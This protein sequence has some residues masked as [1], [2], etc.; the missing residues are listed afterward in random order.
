MAGTFK[1]RYE[2]DSTSEAGSSKRMHGQG[3]DGESGG[4]GGGGPPPLVAPV[5]RHIG[6]WNH[7]I[8]LNCVSWE[9]VGNTIKWLPLH[10]LP[11]MFMYANHK[12]NLHMMQRWMRSSLGYQLHT[13]T[14]TMSNF[15]FLQDA[16]TLAA[17]T[18]ETTTAPTQAAY[19]IAFSPKNQSSEMFQITDAKANKILGWN[20]GKTGIGKTNGDANMLVD[21]GSGDTD[22][23]HL[24][25]QVVVTDSE[26][27]QKDLYALGKHSAGFLGNYNTVDTSDLEP[28]KS[29]P[30]HPD[31]GV[32]LPGAVDGTAPMV[33][34]YYRNYVKNASHI[35]MLK[36]GDEYSWSIHN[37][38]SNYI[39]KNKGAA[40]VNI[41]SADI[42][43]STIN[44]EVT[45]D[46]P[47]RPFMSTNHPALDVTSQQMKYVPTS[48]N[49]NFLILGD[50]AEVV[51]VWPTKENPP[52]SR[53]QKESSIGLLNH[54]AENSK[55]L[56]N[57]FF[58]L[59][60]MKNPDG[61]LIKQRCS[62]MLEQKMAVTFWFRDDVS[63][64]EQNNPQITDPDPYGAE[65]KS[66]PWNILRD[67][68]FTLKALQIRKNVDADTI[69]DAFLQ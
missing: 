34:T 49:P 53:K 69:I 5:P 51:F 47:K 45:N 3:G 60:P 54:F 23:E 24:R 67:Q 11:Q 9:E 39:L 58:I 20:I 37:N 46:R 32:L 12:Q 42:T 16:I 66:L 4:K 65:N 56:N 50:S 8:E 2:A 10:M 33:S 68:D 13:P 18:P 55:T 30:F 44:S 31:V 28:G 15:Q 22:F 63:D 29:H 64:I 1:R 25:Y 27:I 38:C 35:K 61:T 52:Y 7:T 19:M 21:I 43:T 48:G 17:G 41:N 62:V 57:K 6:L 36:H 14:A 26:G 40:G 59:A